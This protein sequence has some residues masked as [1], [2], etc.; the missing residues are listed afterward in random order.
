MKHWLNLRGNTKPENAR[1]T[2]AMTTRRMT[3]TC[4]MKNYYDHSN[5]TYIW[6]DDDR[7]ENNGDIH[8]ESQCEYDFSIE[9]DKETWI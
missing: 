8:Y 1:V 3:P 2:T 5:G 9:N 6:H 7:F 4:T